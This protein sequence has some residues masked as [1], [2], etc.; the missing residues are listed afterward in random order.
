[1]ARRLGGDA[2]PGSTQAAATSVATARLD[3]H[4]AA[5]YEFDVEWRVPMGT[6]PGGGTLAV[7]TGS[8]AAV[9][10]PGAS[11]VRALVSQARAT[12]TV[13]YD[14]NARPALM[15]EPAGARAR[16][17]AFVA[18]ADVVKVSDE[19]LAWLVPGA[20]SVAA[21]RDWL[22]LGPALVVVTFG[23]K[24]AVAVTA[25]GAQHVAAPHVRVID[26]VGAGD[27]FMG[28]LLDGLWDAGLLGAENRA[29]LRA[30]DCST[31]RT[32]LE[33]CV[34]VAAITVS[35]AGANPPHRE[36]LAHL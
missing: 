33:R 3:E 29:A 36:E 18:L 5:S 15:G 4:G 16:I 13:T 7:H 34:A 11:D 20:D 6:V 2:R 30:I 35:R 25:A 31:L 22:A 23:G 28:A 17:E 32:L 9:L 19:D 14:P 24:G 1:M 8:I 10:E 21:A 12:A 27:S 26:T